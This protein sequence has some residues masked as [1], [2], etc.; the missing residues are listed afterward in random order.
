MKK[1]LMKILP[2]N[3]FGTMTFWENDSLEAMMIG[4]KAGHFNSEFD[5]DGENAS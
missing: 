4:I 1:K 3:R 5:S 2:K